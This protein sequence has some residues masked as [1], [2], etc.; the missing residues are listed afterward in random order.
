M[1]VE[2]I[3]NLLVLKEGELFVCARRDGDIRACARSGQGLYSSDTRHLSELSLTVGGRSPTP[4][5]MTT[6]S[7]YEAVVDLANAGLEGEGGSPIPAR[8]LHIRRTF[9]LGDRL[10]QRILIRN[11]SGTRVATEVAIELAA[12]FADMFEVRG[13]CEPVFR[14][15]RS[16]LGRIAHGI[17]FGYVGKDEIRRETVVEVTP[18][19]RVVKDSADKARLTWALALEPLQS[20]EAEFTVEPSL[21]GSRAPQ[22]SFRGARAIFTSKSKE[23]L[24]SC[25]RIDCGS[26][27]LHRVLSRG[28]S[29][30]RSLMTPSEDGEVIAAGIPWYVASF[31]RDA[32]LTSLEM[33]LLTPEPARKTLV[34]LARMQ[35]GTDDPYRD[36]EPGKILH[37]LRRGELA[38]SGSIPH[39]PYYGSVDATPLFLITASAYWHWTADLDTLQQLEPA[40]D[41]ALQWIDTY[42]DRD[43]DG[44]VEYLSR[45]SSGLS[46]HGWKDSQDSIVHV[47]GSPAEGPIALVEVQGYVYLAKRGMADLYRAFGRSERAAL[48]ETE[49]AKLVEAFNEVFWMPE[50]DTY[51]LALDGNKNQVR[52]VSSNPGH[53]LFSGIVDANRAQSVADRLLETDMFSGW[54]VRTLSSRSLAYNPMSYHNG[55]IWPHDNAIIAAGLKRY[56]LSQEALTVARAVLEAALESPESRLPELFCGFEREEGRTYVPYPVACS[57]QAWAAAAPFMLLQSLMGISADAPAELLS[58]CAPVLP[59]HLDHVRLQNVRVGDSRMS[60]DFQKKDLATSCALVDQTGEIRLSLDE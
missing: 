14:E 23:W 2:G 47:D 42:G 7:P 58:I 21:E 33:L 48:L 57:P 24:D 12:D 10:Y 31:G 4:L 52:S 49:A 6:Q 5:S 44:F 40:F 3:G 38:R 22:H 25:A 20:M 11:H 27:G 56:G 37:E 8:A 51:A 26:A 32:L 46:N 59:D 18:P 43:G 9:L 35:A 30:L 28:V 13:A 1:T 34:H 15:P 55:S 54:G 36:A 19:G 45:S 17:S 41:A 39:A 50:E 16:A 53:C 29:D 60:L